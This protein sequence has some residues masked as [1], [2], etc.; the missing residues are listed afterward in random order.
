MRV[1]VYYNLHKKCWSIRALEGENKGRVIAHRHEVCL[2]NVTFK[3]S[4]AG[5]QRVLREGRKNVHAGCVGNWFNCTDPHEEFGLT[6]Q[7]DRGRG[8]L[9]GYNPR[10]AS[11][12]INRK[13]NTPI[14]HATYAWLANKQVWI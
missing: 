14:F 5:R 3:V 12:F 4:E 6:R 13:E 7:V 10:K 8:I 9:V 11:T 1:F 2:E